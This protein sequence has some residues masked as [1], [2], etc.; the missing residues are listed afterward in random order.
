MFIQIWYIQI[1]TNDYPINDNYIDMSQ[2][3][4]PVIR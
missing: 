2:H 1:D 4:N 3:M